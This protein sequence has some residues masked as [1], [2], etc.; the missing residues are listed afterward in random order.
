MSKHHDDASISLSFVALSCRIRS[1][2]CSALS[3]NRTLRSARSHSRIRDVASL[4]F[5]HKYPDIF[6]PTFSMHEG[7]RLTQ[8]DVSC[9]CS[10][11]SLITFSS[12]DESRSSSIFSSHLRVNIAPLARLV[13]IERT[14]HHFDVSPHISWLVLAH[15]LSVSL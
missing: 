13:R 8:R 14:T 6:Y 10:C 1:T 2:V 9:S 7:P 3:L 15:S 5:E 4:R 12:R 11:E